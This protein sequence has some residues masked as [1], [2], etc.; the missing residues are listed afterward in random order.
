MRDTGPGIP[1]E[2]LG[3]IFERFY[4]GSSGSKRLRR[5][6]G[7]GLSL[8]KLIVEKHGGMIRASSTPGEGTA[9]TITLPRA[10]LN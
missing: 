1:P 9:F 3:R 2:E 4:Q 5:G 6:S 8:A 7:I 10:W